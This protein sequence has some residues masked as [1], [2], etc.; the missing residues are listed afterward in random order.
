MPKQYE[1][2]KKA[3]LRAGKSLRE[4]KRIAAATYNKKHP[5]S[6]VHPG[7]HKKK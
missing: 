7:Y 3:L 1:E 5:N 2:I 6:P 4:A